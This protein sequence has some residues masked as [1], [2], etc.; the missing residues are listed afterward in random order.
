MVHIFNEHEK[1]FGYIFKTIQNGSDR[2][3]FIPLYGGL[4]PVLDPF[5]IV[6]ESIDVRK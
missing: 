1:L 3:P 6:P 4:G 5:D 2:A